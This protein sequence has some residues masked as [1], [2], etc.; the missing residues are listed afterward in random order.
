LL[1]A[2]DV[3]LGFPDRVARQPERYAMA[4]DKSVVEVKAELQ[5]VLASYVLRTGMPWRDLP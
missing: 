2:I 3:V 4:K 5:R 1:I